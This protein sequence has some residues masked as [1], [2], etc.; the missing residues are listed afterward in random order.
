MTTDI[1]LGTTQSGKRL[2]LNEGKRWTHMHVIGASGR[3]KSY[4]LE[5]LIR[6]DIK[7]RRGVCLIDPHGTLYDKIV[8][9]CAQHPHLPWGKLILLDASAPGWTFGFNPLHFAGADISFCVDSMVQ[10]C[11]QV[12]GGED[13]SSMPLLTRVLRGVFHALA[14]KNLTLLE[15]HHL[16]NENDQVLRRL[17]TRDIADPMMREQWEKWNEL[18]PRDFRAEFGSA[19]NRIANFLFTEVIR[20]I[21]G[22][23]APLIDFR[24][25]MDEGAVVLVS[26]RRRARFSEMNAKTLG[27]LLVNDMFLNAEGRP[28]GSRPFYLYIDECGQYLNESIGRILNETRKRGLHLILANHH[29]SQL[30]DAGSKVYSAVMSNAQTKIIFGGINSDD[31]DTMVREVFLDLDLEEPKHSLD[32]VVAVGQEKIT[33]LGGSSGRTRATSRSHASSNSR[34]TSRTIYSGTSESESA[35]ILDDGQEGMVRASWGISAGEG[36]SESSM[37]GEVDSTATS[38]AVS[39]MNSWTESF[40]TLYEKVTGGHFTLEEQRYKKA[41]WLK[42]QPRQLALLAPPDFALVPFRVADVR[43]PDISERVIQ[44]FI[45][46]RFREAPFVQE[47]QQVITALAERA[48]RIAALR[49]PDR[50][51]EEPFD[52]WDNG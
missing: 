29:L 6:Q 10:A 7:H 9:W 1:R 46:A 11:A 49:R 16:I 19:T 27:T 45:E 33:L 12:W 40:K 25:V 18:N 52:P 50:E 36:E 43:P 26:L 31:A 48:E 3:G 41:A 21:I 2:Y 15:A 51:A 8:A 35:P 38:D 14:D 39:E 42:K 28:E 5:Y 47:T 23:T 20:H 13:T 24:K 34:G 4:F 22:Q 32:R 30:K 44:R 17:L 37:E